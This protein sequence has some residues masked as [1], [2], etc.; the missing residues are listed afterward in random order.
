MMAKRL[1]PKMMSLIAQ[2]LDKE[3]VSSDDIHFILENCYKIEDRIQESKERTT[4]CN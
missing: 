4:F 2:Y 3:K 1:T